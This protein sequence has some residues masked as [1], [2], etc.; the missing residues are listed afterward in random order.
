MSTNK[1]RDYDNAIPVSTSF[2]RPDITEIQQLYQV[3][4]CELELKAAHARADAEKAE[5]ELLEAQM[6]KQ[7]QT[8]NEVN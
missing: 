6:T 5:R 7:E 2:D 4:L 1:I 8:P 3:D